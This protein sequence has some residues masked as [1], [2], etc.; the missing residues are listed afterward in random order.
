MCY[1]FIC[2]YYVLNT[3]PFSQVFVYQRD[4]HWPQHVDNDISFA[5][6]SQLENDK[7]AV[8]GQLIET[9]INAKIYIDYAHATIS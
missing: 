3:S 1:N 6:F 2:L 5:T 9:Q 8:L 7:T 4:S